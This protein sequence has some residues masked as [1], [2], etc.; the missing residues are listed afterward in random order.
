VDAP[1]QG[2]LSVS[3]RVTHPVAALGFSV[4]ESCRRLK[5]PVRDYLADILPGLADAPLQRI[6]ELTPAVRAARTSSMHLV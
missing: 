4:I 5:I 3:V 1:R 6:A 2:D